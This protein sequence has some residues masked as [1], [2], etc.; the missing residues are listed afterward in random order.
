MA[1]ILDVCIF[2][3]EL[4]LK[5]GAETYRVE[6][7]VTRMARSYHMARVNVYVTPTAIIMTMRGEE[8]IVDH[9]ELLRI[10]DRTT[11]LHK[12]SLVNEVSRQVASHDIPLEIVK[13]KLQDINQSTPIYP[14]WVQLLAAALGSGCFMILFNGTWRDFLP[15]FIVGGGGY[16]VFLKVQQLV[17][18]KFFSEVLASFVIGLAAVFLIAIGLGKELDKIIIGSVMPLVPGM[19]I[20]NAVRDLMAGHLVSGVSRGVEALLTAAAIGSGI[21]VV[22]TFL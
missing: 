1:D 4:M 11:D 2:A 17:N 19:A 9:T 12:L 15:A 8:E 21:A 6:D 14:Y 3:G 20:T 18:V 13:Q 10:T 7:T 5:N 16:A 22:L